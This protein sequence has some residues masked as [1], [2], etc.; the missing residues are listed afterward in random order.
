MEHLNF[1]DDAI[2]A[3]M[4]IYTTATGIP[5]HFYQNK[6]LFSPKETKANYPNYCKLVCKKLVESDRCEKEHARIGA[7]AVKEGFFICH[8]GIFIYAIPI[9]NQKEIVGSL[10]YGHVR[11]SDP[12]HKAIA[13]QYYESTLS[14]LRLGTDERRTFEEN[15]NQTRE[16]DD[17]NGPQSLPLIQQVYMVQS[18]IAGFRSAVISIKEE[19]TQIDRGIE[20]IAHEFQIRLQALYADSENLLRSL[21]PEGQSSSESV[22]TSKELIRGLKRLNV[23]VQN[24]SMGLGE[25]D[26]VDVN[27][28]EIIRESIDLY[29]SEAEGKYVTF[30]VKIEEPSTIE[31]SRNHMTHLLH[32]L[33]SN[34]VKYSY[35]GKSSS[36]RYIIVAG[37]KKFEHYEV[38]V[39]NYGIGIL[40]NES[41]QIFVKG[42]R[43]I[44]TRDERRTGAGLGLAISKEIIEYH[45]GKIY[46]TS[47]STGGGYVTT[48]RVLL[49]YTWSRKRD[50]Q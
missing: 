12:N 31:V 1:E 36:L 22:E 27:L 28:G 3:L 9:R 15:Y 4:Q 29:T 26:V 39:Q 35:K 43:G 8:A 24:L 2:N 6:Q 40:P 13:R 47:S 44:L 16:I 23:L 37:S 11:L 42:Y 32:N 50:K 5:I 17:S 20:N 45:K 49:P 30:Q 48:F 21:Q 7:T 41:E 18:K 46:V 33:I 14:E 34:A 25:Y 10:L 38:L 19:K